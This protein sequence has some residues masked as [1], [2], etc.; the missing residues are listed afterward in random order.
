[1]FIHWRTI[2]RCLAY[3]AMLL[4]LNAAAAPLPAH[5]E[6]SHD[7]KT[8]TPIHH[9]IVIIGENRSFDNLFATYMPKKGQ[10]VLNLYSEGIVNAD[11]TPGPNFST[12]AQ[13]Q[14]VD[15]A[16]F[17]LSPGGKTRTRRCRRRTRAARRSTPAIRIR[18][19]LQRLAPQPR[20]NPRCFRTT[21]ECC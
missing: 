12:A 2:Q 8:A 17:Q 3:P 1:M 18:R 6:N 7:R 15:P 4:T 5:D 11:G 16:I 20:P 13:M 10:T 9:V 14:A 19:R 21:W